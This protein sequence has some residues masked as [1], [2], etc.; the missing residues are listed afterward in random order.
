MAMM[1]MAGVVTVD[2]TVEARTVDGWSV[3]MTGGAWAPRKHEI[4]L[5]VLNCCAK[6]YP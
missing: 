3:N 6:Q 1:V 4:A 5:L 2:H